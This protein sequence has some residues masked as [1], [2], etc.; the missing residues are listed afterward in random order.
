MY[1]NVTVIS[2]SAFHA[3]GPAYENEHSPNFMHSRAT[4][5]M[6]S[7]FINFRH[8]QNNFNCN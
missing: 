3:E 8:K 7:S 4:H 1:K 5:C 2:R 6:I